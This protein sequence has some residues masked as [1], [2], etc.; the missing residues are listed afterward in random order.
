M[1]T[2]N[3]IIGQIDVNSSET[4]IQDIIT[5]KKAVPFNNR[6]AMKYLQSKDSDLKRV[7]E[8]LLSGQRPGNK[9]K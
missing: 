6:N 4:L 5:G 8:L 3:G 2:E 1:V 9:E 7:K